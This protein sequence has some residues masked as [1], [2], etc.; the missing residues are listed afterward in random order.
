MDNKNDEKITITVSDDHN[1]GVQ[2]RAKPQ[3]PLRKI[4]ERYAQKLAVSRNE[5][6]FY[7]DGNKLQDGDT[8]E[9]AG[10]TDGGVIEVLKQ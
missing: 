6:R 10:I 1:N 7:Y 5:L 9:E 8:P 3:V 4:F 2:F